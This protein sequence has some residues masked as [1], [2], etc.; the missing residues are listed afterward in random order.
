MAERLEGMVELCLEKERKRFDSLA[1]FADVRAWV[2]FTS[3]R[4]LDISGFWKVSW[5][6]SSESLAIM[7]QCMRP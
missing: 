6:S 5:I 2:L 3:C 4:R 1:E 7:M